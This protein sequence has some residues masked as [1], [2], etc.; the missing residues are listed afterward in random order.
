MSEVPAAC[1]VVDEAEVAARLGQAAVTL[2]DAP[3]GAFL[4]ERVNGILEL[5]RSGERRGTGV[6]VDLGGRDLRPGTPGVSRR[7]PLARAVRAPS[8]IIDATAGLGRDSALLAGLGCD[9]VAIERHPVIA[10]LLRDGLARGRASDDPVVARAAERIELLEGDAQALLQEVGDPDV[11][12]LDPMYPP[13][14]GASA[15][16]RKGAQM[17]RAVVGADPDM[18]AV[19]DVA[20]RIAINR[21]VLKRPHSE[22]PLGGAATVS[23]SGKLVRYDVYARSA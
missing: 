15:L 3:D 20:R 4:L 8:R 7:Q 14:P 10:A 16:P 23:F 1:V 13:R 12:Y 6:H 11:V 5:R 9:V 18:Q 22:P 21:V 2:A 17:L 19:F